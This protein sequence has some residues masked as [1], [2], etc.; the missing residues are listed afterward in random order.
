MFFTTCLSALAVTLALPACGDDS[1]R[2]SDSGDSGGTIT[3]GA[4][5]PG[6][7]TAGGGSDS[8]TESS[9]SAG[10]ESQ[11]Q[12]TSGTTTA[13]ETEGVSDTGGTTG[14]PPSCEDEPPPGFMV[15]PDPACESEPQVGMF[16]PIIEWHKEVWEV[17]PGSKSSVTTPILVQLTDDNLDGEINTLDMPDLVFITYDGV[18]VLR[19]VS[20]D[21]QTEIFS[22]PGNGLWR[23]ES[24]AGADIDG[25]GVV[26]ILT[27]NQNKVLLAFENDGALKWQSAP[28]G[29]HVGT[30]DNAPAISDM[31][32]DGTPEIVVG[33]A[34]L[35]NQGNLIGA[36]EHGI[37]V[38]TGNANGSASMS[39]AVDLDDDGQ[40]EVVV[41]DA[42]YAMDGTT[43]WYNGQHDGYPAVGD[44]F[45]NGI[46]YIVVVSNATVRVQTSVDGT[47][48]WS[49]AIP[50]GKGGPPTIEDFDGDGLAEIGVAGFNKY[51]VFEGDT[52][53]VLWS[54]TT[55]D[56][57]SGITGSSVYDFEG[58][59]IADV[60]YCDETTCWVYNGQDGAVKMNL[61][62]HNSGTRLEYPIIADVDN[63]E[64]VEIVFVSEPYNGNYRGITVIGDADESW[65]PGRKIW[66]QHAYHITNVADDG[67]VPA[68]AEQNWKSYNNFRSGDLSANDGLAAPDLALEIAELCDKSCG[69]GGV[70]TIWV[71]LG[72]VGAAPLTAG[73][74]IEVYGTI[75]G[76]EMLLDEVPYNET[77][78]PGVF[79]DSLPI[80]VQ[81]ANLESARLV[82]VPNEE[83]CNVDEDNEILL[84]PPF[85]MVPE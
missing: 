20:G 33:R 45:G 74:V 53:E 25:D 79:T 78:E 55:Q 23:D 12:T 1:G 15:P 32:G 70:A 73:A 76:M 63:D 48:V 75:N 29:N 17:E 3:E 40:Q 61:T 60:V 31:N 13:G 26:E 71:H 2:G 35:D 83:E 66:N 68:L 65:R 22:V 44:M 77:I 64:Q 47:V 72:N 85:C 7:T 38:H 28:L 9:L 5:G 54:N 52:G 41:G 56:N 10:S 21:G 8:M 24:V 81:A 19:A 4:T 36:G 27:V 57:S 69:P 18:G 84:M 11:G 37:G 16:N 6:S 51:T 30:Y 67:T 80:E 42:L 82:A 39:F 46:P 43:I 62:E 58:D 34:I 14:E 50:G 49:S 59:G